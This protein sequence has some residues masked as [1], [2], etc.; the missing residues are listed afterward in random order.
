MARARINQQRLILIV[1]K[2]AHT[3]YLLNYLL[4]RE[5][6]NVISTTDCEIAG[7][8][9][10]RLPPADVIFL[11]VAFINDGQCLFLDILREMPGWQDTP[12]LLLAEHNSMDNVNAGLEAGARDYIVQPFHHAEL[13]SQIKRYS[14]KLSPA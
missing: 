7:R 8:L 6:Y 12:I 3:A 10:T 14:P 11:D 2:D 5:D 4:S 13:M 9:L 1:E